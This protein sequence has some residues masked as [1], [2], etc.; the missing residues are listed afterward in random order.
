MLFRSCSY[1]VGVFV[2]GK[3]MPAIFLG[4]PMTSP[5]FYS[6]LYNI[7]WA[8]PDVALTLVIYALLY[9]VRSLRRYLLREDLAVYAK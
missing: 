4:M 8:G 5:W 9:R 1:L 7:T 6:F 2:W 3:Y